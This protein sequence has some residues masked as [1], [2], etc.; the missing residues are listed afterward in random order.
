MYNAPTKILVHEHFE[1]KKK[2]TTETLTKKVNYN[3]LTTN[4]L[5]IIIK[6]Y[7]IKPQKIM[8]PAHGVM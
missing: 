2:K 5:I 1:K 3:N 6:I 7:K 4:H 8:E